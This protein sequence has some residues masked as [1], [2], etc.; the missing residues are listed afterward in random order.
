MN[1]AHHAQSLSSIAA[2]CFDTATDTPAVPAKVAN[3]V[4]DDQA[5]MPSLAPMLVQG[6]SHALPMHAAADTKRIEA[7]ATAALPAHTLMQRAGLAVARLALA[8]APYAQR[9]VVVAGPGNNGGDGLEAA[10]RL[11]LIGKSVTAVLTRDPAAIPSDARN[12]FQRASD[13][14]VRLL[15]QWPHEPFDLVIDALLG[16]GAVRVPTGPLADAWERL[17]ASTAP[18]L[19]IDLPSGLDADLGLPS[20]HK[21]PPRATHTLSLLTLKPG[22]FT[23]FGRDFCGTV[24]L[25]RLGLEDHRNSASAW[26]GCREG[27]RPKESTAAAGPER[28][29]S[30]HKGSF[31][32]V[33]VVGGAPGMQGALVLASRAALAAGSGRVFS[34]A[35]SHDGAKHP[36]GI[37][38]PELMARSTSL[39]N[40]RQALAQSVVVCG[41]GGGDEIKPCL[42]TLLGTAQRLVL[43]AD[44]LNAISTDTM[45]QSQLKSRAVRGMSTIITPHPLEASRLLAWDGARAVQHNR[46]AAAQ[47]LAQDWQVV[48]VLKGSGSIIAAPGEVPIVNPTGNAL[49]ATAGTGDVLAGWIAGAW[50]CDTRRRKLQ[51]LAAHVVWRHGAAADEA[52]RKPSPAESMSASAL[53]NAMHST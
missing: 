30:A 21:A 26:L 23:G 22:L 11:R 53:I 37:A 20:P 32:D 17:L 18:V 27:A 13:S 7:Q 47:Q 15:A 48:V 45:L 33:L 19:A 50:A 46:F 35:L 4:S 1:S 25:D 36:D 43:D 42:P 12:A 51:D 28:L 16:I 5:M 49:L 8:V 44:A 41:C 6:L 34:V 39:L 29:H 31:G 9:I 40:D 10:H 52:L 24:W 14:G 3:Q 38:A 2:P